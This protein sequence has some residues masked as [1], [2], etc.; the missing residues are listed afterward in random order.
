MLVE[1]CKAESLDGA[2]VIGS[3]TLAAAYRFGLT[4]GERN[5]INA[6]FG[7]RFKSIGGLA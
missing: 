1:N 4:A 5:E 2:V 6:I 3:V 7:S